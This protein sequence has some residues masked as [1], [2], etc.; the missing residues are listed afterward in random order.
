MNIPFVDLKAQYESLKSEIDGAIQDILTNTAFI[1]G[2]PVADFSEAFAKEYGVDHFIPVANGTDALYIAMKMLGI[3]AG[4]EVITTA[5]SWISTSETITQAGADPV[6]VDVDEYYTIDASKIEDKITSKTKAIIPVHLYGQMADMETIMA[7][8]EKHNL[9]VIE[10]CAQSHMSELK[11]KRAGLW[12]DVATFSFYPGKNLGA[13]GDAGGMITNDGELAMKCRRFANHG[14]LTKHHHE[15]EG[16]NSRL[17]ALQA[18]ILSVKLPHLY[19][20]TQER[21]R[22]G[23]RY[24]ELLKDVP[25]VTLPKLRPESLHSFHVF[26]IK[27]ADRDSLKE[28]LD[29]R[30]VPTQIHYPKAMPFMPAYARYNATPADYPNSFELQENEL[31]L[32]IFPEMTEEQIDYVCTSIKQYYVS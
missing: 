5:S 2:K 20:W 13:Y 3:G 7:I 28:G 6:F 14:A 23:H 27:V 1:G 26:A 17:D 9:K 15:V 8:A 22:V 30:G 29:Q 18:A 19:K 24:L 12:G 32:P 25:Q 4:D 21:I 11:G 16:I 31:S 10:D